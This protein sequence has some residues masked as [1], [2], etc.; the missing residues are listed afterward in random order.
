MLKFCSF[1]GIFLMLMERLTVPLIT[2]QSTLHF[3]HTSNSH[4]SPATHVHSH[5]RDF[6]LTSCLDRHSGRYRQFLSMFSTICVN[7][8]KCEWAIANM[9]AALLLTAQK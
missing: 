5:A 3:I 6:G 4:A 8:Q 9:A 1:V 2:R 7:L